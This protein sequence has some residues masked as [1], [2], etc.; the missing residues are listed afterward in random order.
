MPQELCGLLS[1]VSRDVLSDQQML[2]LLCLDI[3]TLVRRPEV[4]ACKIQL[5]TREVLP[6]PHEVPLMSPPYP[7]SGRPEMTGHGGATPMFMQGGGGFHS[8]ATPM[9]MQGGGFHG[10]VPPAGFMHPGNMRG[11]A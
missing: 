9:F 7:A 2:D 3:P 8:G 4:K 1:D 6:G 11:F 10:G 5:L